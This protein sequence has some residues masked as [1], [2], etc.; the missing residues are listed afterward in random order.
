MS[1]T[2][3]QGEKAQASAQAPVTPAPQPKLTFGAFMNKLLAGTATGII[4][5]LIPNA[6]LAAILK[7]FNDIPIIQD[8]INAGIIIQLATPIIVGTIIGTQ[9]GFN[10]NRSMI[11]GSATLVGSGVIKFNTEA[12]AFIGSGTGD[13]INIMITAAIAVLMVKW[14]GGKLGSVEIIA[15]PIIVGVGAGVIGWLLYPY[16]TQVTVAIGNGI[17]SFTQLQPLFMSILIAMSFATIIISPI[18]TVGIGLAIGLTGMS[19]GAAAMGIA[20]TTVVLVIHSWKVNSSGIT[21]AI[22]LGGMKLMMPNLF[23]YPIILVPCLF[24]AIISSISVVLFNIQGLP[25]S[26]G[27]GL[28][29]LV[30]P[31]ASLD[32]GLSLPLLLLAWFVIP[33][34][35]GLVAKFLFEKTLK[36]Y[37]P[38]V[39]FKFQ[40]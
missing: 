35:V 36:L 11:V 27:F 8:I 32:A 22:A 33:I 26:A 15:M 16:V 24:T 38:N 37:D 13:V 23:K 4:I 12:N 29:G 31:L 25:Q 18:T 1:N 20:A 30:G 2:T 28:V 17:N 7:Y 3:T 14:I 19:A 21:L 39:V 40:G 34:I 5:A 6:V 10:I 9:F